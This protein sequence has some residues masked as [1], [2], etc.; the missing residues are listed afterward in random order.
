MDQV[1][2]GIYLPGTKETFIRL[3]TRYAQKYRKDI[4]KTINEWGCQI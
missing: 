4:F 3:S 1:K 2:M